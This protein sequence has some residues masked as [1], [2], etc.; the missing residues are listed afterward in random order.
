MDIK[1]LAVSPQ[2]SYRRCTHRTSTGPLSAPSWW[3]PEY[4]CT[5]TSDQTEELSGYQPETKQNENKAFLLCRVYVYKH[6]SSHAHD[7]QTRNN[8]LWSTQSVAP[9][10]SRTRYSLRGS[11]LPSHR[12]N[13][14]VII[15]AIHFGECAGELHNLIPPSPFHHRT[16]RQSARRHRFMVDIP[17]TRTKRF[18]SSF[19]VR[20][21]REWNSL[22]ESVFPDGYNLGVFKARVNRLLMGRRAPSP[23]TTF[24][25]SHG[26]APCGNRTRYTLRGGRLPSHRTNRAVKLY[27]IFYFYHNNKTTP[28][29][30]QVSMG[31]GDGLPSGDT[32]DRL[33][34]YTIKKA[35]TLLHI[36][37]EK[38]EYHPSTFLALGEARESVRLLLTKNHPVPTPAFRAGAP[39]NPLGSPQL[40]IRH[41]PYWAPSVVVRWLFE[42]RRTQCIVV[43]FLLCRVYVYK[44]TSS[45]TR[46]TQTRNNNLWIT[47]RVVPCGNRT[48]DTLHGSQLPSHRA[49]RA[50][51][52]HHQS[53]YPTI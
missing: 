10:G 19:L 42:A 14:A 21:A 4:H 41:Q 20:T 47:Q 16:T 43:D 37:S 11:Q 5:Q 24:C 45:H 38:G 26:V 53:D 30:F 2:L 8:N 46:D 39:V 49:N 52:I 7:T 32:S 17:P 25:G 22:P 3:T 33:P 18:A 27:C 6:T 34:A 50:V 48:R 36:C 23:E 44:H 12:T 35:H 51:I 28:P 13:R 40:R 29:V 1:C 31:G 15:S 9:C